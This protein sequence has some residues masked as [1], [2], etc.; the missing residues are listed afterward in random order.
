MRALDY[1]SA[2]V[3]APGWQLTALIGTL[4]IEASK[5]RLARERH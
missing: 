2:A 1:R 3:T 5:E 4:N